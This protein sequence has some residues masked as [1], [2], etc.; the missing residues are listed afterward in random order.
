MSFFFVEC[1][2]DVVLVIPVGAGVSTLPPLL[3]ALFCLSALRRCVIPRCS[4]HT[5]NIS[6]GS[7]RT[8]AWLI[9]ARGRDRQ[10]L[11]TVHTVHTV[12]YLNWIF[13]R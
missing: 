13:V 3:L 7:S 9:F 8:P 6:G 12:L 5:T 4:G 10:A 2:I 1:D 11:H